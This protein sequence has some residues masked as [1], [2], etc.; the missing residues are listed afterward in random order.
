MTALARKADPAPDPF[1]A[2]FAANAARLPGAGLAWLDER[3]A[4]A[5]AD[6]SVA[7]IPNRRVEA[8]KFT[9]LASALDDGLVSGGA[10]HGRLRA[11]T[12]DG[13]EIV[14]LAALDAKTPANAPEPNGK[15][16]TLSVR[17][18]RRATSR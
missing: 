3:R 6:F 10:F 14:D 16:E 7:G 2:D 8:W 4:R 12:T 18:C 9:D 5:M 13:I 15:T 11:E 17:S 1:Q